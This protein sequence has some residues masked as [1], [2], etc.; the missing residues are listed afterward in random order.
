MKEIWNKI[1]SQ[2][3][4]VYGIEPNNFFKEFVDKIEPGKILLPGEGEGRNTVYAAS[5]NWD[6]TA[7]DFSEIARNKALKLAQKNN[8]SLIIK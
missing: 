7:F 4:F 1:Y 3:N 5:K 2:E 8:V 6:V